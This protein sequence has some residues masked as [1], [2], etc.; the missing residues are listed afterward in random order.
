MQDP[1]A[2][3]TIE[4]LNGGDDH[5]GFF[6]AGRFGVG[7]AAPQSEYAQVGGGGSAID[8][9]L[10]K[11]LNSLF[12]ELIGLSDPN[13]AARISVRLEDQI[14]GGLNNDASLTTTRWQADNSPAAAIS[15]GQ[16]AEQSIGDLLLE[17]VK[18]WK[19]DWAAD[20]LLSFA[21]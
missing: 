11:S 16:K 2:D 15:L 6:R 21:A 7:I 12:T 18:R 13:D 19:I 3:A 8:P 1:S 4:S 14:N 5:D 10:S 20:E 17:I 9:H